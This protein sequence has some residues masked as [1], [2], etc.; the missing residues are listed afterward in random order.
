MV[1]TTTDIGWISSLKRE[2]LS[3]LP[4]AKHHS[5]Y[6][7][8]AFKH[9]RRWTC[10]AFISRQIIPR[11]MNASDQSLSR[12]PMPNLF[13]KPGEN[14]RQAVGVSDLCGCSWPADVDPIEDVIPFSRRYRPLGPLFVPQLLQYCPNPYC[15]TAYSVSTH[16]SFCSHIH[17][18]DFPLICATIYNTL[19]I[20][21]SN[22][23]KPAPQ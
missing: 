7:K 18:L 12:S 8:D 21:N 17:T 15:V 19:S 13:R 4:A 10:T 3:H 9:S 2:D 5:T 1:L 23:A 16:P 14:G 11:P 20:S 22:L 6:H